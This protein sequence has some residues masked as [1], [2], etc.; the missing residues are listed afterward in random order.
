MVT[1]DGH[2]RLKSRKAEAKEAYFWLFRAAENVLAGWAEAE[3]GQLRV[4]GKVKVPH[5]IWFSTPRR[6]NGLQ[7]NHR[8]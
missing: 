2:G 7:S 4:T 1:D 6:S 3:E 8:Y 5:N